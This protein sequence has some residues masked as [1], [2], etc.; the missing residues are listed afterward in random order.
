MDSTPAF[1]ISRGYHV[2]RGSGRGLRQRQ[3]CA[4]EHGSWITRRGWRQVHSFKEA[5]HS[6]ST[7]P[8][9]WRRHCDSSSARL[10]FMRASAGSARSLCQHSRS[11]HRVCVRRPGDND[12]RRHLKQSSK[13]QR[14]EH[15]DVLRHRGRASRQNHVCAVRGPET[16]S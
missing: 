6:D 11:D 7:V 10:R 1:P 14:C 3:S 12:L 9:R 15:G 2:S 16:R 4:D 13:A 8:S 5:M